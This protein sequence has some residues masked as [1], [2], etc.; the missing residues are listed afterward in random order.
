[1]RLEQLYA[2]VEI[3]H[4]GSMTAAA[5]KLHTSSQNMSKIIGQLE[6]EFN[7]ILFTRSNQGVFLT[8]QGKIIYE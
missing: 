4:S 7:T 1:M 3:A 6:K 5:Q 8:P 2:V